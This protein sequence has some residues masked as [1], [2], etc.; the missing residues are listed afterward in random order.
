MSRFEHRVCQ[1]DQLLKGKLLTEGP[2]LHGRTSV[3][4]NWR[5]ADEVLDLLDMHVQR[6]QRT[7][8]TGCR[9]STVLFA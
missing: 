1:D 2:S 7:L 3:L 4:Q 6:S 9:Y 5:L 8:E